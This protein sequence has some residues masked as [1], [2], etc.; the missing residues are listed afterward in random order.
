[1]A[2]PSSRSPWSTASIAA[3]FSSETPFP[4]AH[5]ARKRF[6]PA[7]EAGPMPGRESRGLVEK[8][9]LGPALAGHRFPAPTF[10]FADT[11]DPGLRG[12]APLEQG[13]RRGIVNDPA[14]AGEQA[15]LGN[16]NDLAVRRDAILQGHGLCRRLQV[17]RRILSGRRDPRP[18]ISSVTATARHRLFLPRPVGYDT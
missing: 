4:F 2:V 8:E 14:V 7:E 18:R 5:A 15:A 17:Y 11:D 1:L 3:A 12:P 13:P 6:A 9:Q 10:V 16:G